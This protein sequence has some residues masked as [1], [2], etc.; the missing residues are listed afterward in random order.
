MNIHPQIGSVNQAGLITTNPKVAALEDI[1]AHPEFRRLLA[2]AQQV[3]A[4]Q[5]M[6]ALAN[7]TEQTR[8][9]AEQGKGLQEQF[10]A[11]MVDYEQARVEFHAKVG[12]V[13]VA[14]QAYSRL[15]G[16]LPSSFPEMLF[17]TINAPTLKPAGPYQWSSG[18]TTTQSASM[19]WAESRC[20]DWPGV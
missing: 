16:A 17:G 14:A 4:D 3:K 13:W 9:R 1:Q 10:D 12:A 18:F 8:H 11:A 20:R 7:Q 5:R 15:T 6:Q 2:E 19:A